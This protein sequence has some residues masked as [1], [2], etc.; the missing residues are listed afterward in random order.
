MF[1]TLHRLTVYENY[2]NIMLYKGG[3]KTQVSICFLTKEAHEKMRIIYKKATPE[4]LAPITE[5]SIN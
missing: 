2:R 4:L 3:K 5:M 1:I